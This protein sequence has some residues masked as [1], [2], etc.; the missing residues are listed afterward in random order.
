MKKL[1][2]TMISIC[3]AAVLFVG[4]GGNT[5]ADPT[6]AP[7]KAPTAAPN[8]E[9]TA[10][11]ETTATPVPKPTIAPDLVDAIITS[12]D[13]FDE[14]YCNFNLCE[15]FVNSQDPYLTV[16]VDSGDVWFSIPFTETVNADE[17]PVMAIKYKT[18]YGTKISAGS[19]LY[20]ITTGGGPSPETGW[21]T[22]PS[23]VQ[24]GD[25]HVITLNL[26]E[27][28]TAAGKDFTAMR[29]PCITNTGKNL[30]VAYM[31]AFKSVED[32]AAYDAAHEAVYGDLL[33][34]DAPPTDKNESLPATVEKFTEYTETFEDFYD[35][36]LTGLVGSDFEDLFKIAMGADRSNIVT[37]DGNLLCDL[38]YDAIAYRERADSGSAYTLT[39][40]IKTDNSAKDFGG[41][42]VNYG[43]ENNE[44][45]S[46]FETNGLRKDGEGS[47]VGNSGIGVTFKTGGVVEIYVLTLNAENKLD[48]ISYEVD[49]GIDFSA[50]YQNITVIDDGKGV[51]TFKANDTLIATVNYSKDG[52]LPATAA[53]YNERY[54]R[55]ASIC[56]ASGNKVAETDS[57]LISFTK[58]F[59]FGGRSHSILLDDISIKNN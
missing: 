29:L 5:D 31:G 14:T 22:H 56:D 48:M 28:F 17:Y 25:W 21:W 20:A 47:L 27:T 53:A 19:H 49:T 59:G 4:C 10:T 13:E 39:F 30:Y 15:G 1:I 18:G 2:I 54:Y 52:L 38:V 3:L 55:T 57:A 51:V 58:A 23:F 42:I 26:N 46:F 37:K 36:K 34:A 45:G 40:K 11:P 8:S 16:T 7:S 41:F 44:A 24:D 9:P 6:A 32:A 33:V 50:D 12:F 43:H 35:I